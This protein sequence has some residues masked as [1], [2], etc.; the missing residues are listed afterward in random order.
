L[1]T[2]EERQ[3]LLVQWNDTSA[4]YPRESAL[5]DLI[6]AQCAHTPQSIAVRCGADELSYEALRARSDA[7]AS[8]LADMG[9]G[10]GDRVAV[11]MER[12]FELVV[13]LLGVLKAGAAYVPI[14]MDLPDERIRFMLQDAGAAL[15]LVAEVAPFGARELDVPLL[16]LKS[17]GEA[18]LHRV[19]VSRPY[20]ENA[21]AYVLY[22]SGTTGQ[23]KGV[24][25][26]HRSLVNHM[27]WMQARFPLNGDDRVLQKTPFG[28]DASVWELF[29]PLV[30]GAQLVMA[31]PGSHRVPEELGEAVRAQGITVL[32]LVPT[33][34]DAM[35]DAGA[36]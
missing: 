28:F 24:A 13:A 36:L 20:G 30:A 8:V 12:R 1:L 23:P 31:A 19:A 2:A 16:A 22:T 32:Q 26:T 14:D 5:H 10:T 7:L 27:A 9:I 3:R 17:D 33:M 34:L 15:M 11:C 35:L 6:D 4:A 18:R 29:A 25:I 21:I